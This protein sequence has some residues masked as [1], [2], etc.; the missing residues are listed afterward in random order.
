MSLAHLELNFTQSTSWSSEDDIIFPG[1]D[2]ELAKEKIYTPATCARVRI[3]M[4]GLLRSSSAQ[5]TKFASLAR[6]NGRPDRALPRAHAISKGLY[7]LQL[8]ISS[9]LKI[10]L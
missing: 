9:A 8:H 4:T 5:F 7:K 2:Q 6:P 1:L 10:L 3:K